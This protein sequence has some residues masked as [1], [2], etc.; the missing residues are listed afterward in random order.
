MVVNPD[1]DGCTETLSHRKILQKTQK[2]AYSKPK[3]Y[4][5]GFLRPVQKDVNGEKGVWKGPDLKVPCL[6]LM[7]G[8][9]AF[10]F[11]C[12]LQPV[13]KGHAPVD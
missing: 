10:D 3:E 5:R 1:V 12:Y 9:N 2:T 8:E 6:G 7:C 4:C 13:S 11:V